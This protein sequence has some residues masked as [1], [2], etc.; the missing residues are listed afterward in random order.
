MQYT[1]IKDTFFASCPK[2]LEPEL[3][4]ELKAR[5]ISQYTE[6]TGGVEFQCSTLKAIEFLFWTRISSR[7]FKKFTSFEIKSE[8]DLY[9]EGKNIKWKSYLELDQTFSIKT[10]LGNSP[11]G[12]MWSQFKN[13]LF[14]SQR[15]K[16]SIVDQFQKKFNER[17]SVDTKAPDVPLL[18]RV[19]PN[20]NPHSRKEKVDLYL[21]LCGEPLSYRGYRLRNVD[22]P[23]R[24]NVA[25]GLLMRTNLLQTKK[26]LDPM[27]GS[28]TFLF[29]ALY[30]LADLPGSFLKVER[31]MDDGEDYFAFV[32]SQFY[33]KDPKLQDEVKALVKSIQ[34]EIAG[35]QVQALE[36]IACD[37]DSG[38]IKAVE[39]NKGVH[40]LFSIIQSRQKNFFEQYDLEGFTIVCNPPYGE[41]LDVE[42]N[43]S[44]L[45][46]EIA[47]HL[48]QKLKGNDFY[49]L[50]ASVS[51]VK[52][53]GLK[54]NKKLNIRNGNLDA[55]FLHYQ[56]Y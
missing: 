9:F 23:V 15:L 8:K 47:D 33:K 6:F 1:K 31:F 29:E 38:S 30:Q 26:V 7:V 25:A 20:D 46:K 28:G 24:E 18:M 44:G 27:A 35:K 40:P 37:E 53:F 13:T 12:K 17:P 45:Y 48:K 32:R 21:D 19:S 22:A 49:M 39:I 14:L 41:R 4:Q 34:N 10:L 3:I 52:G 11:N 51:G 43:M 42:E 36:L 55:K 54:P 2:G 56:I 5:K 50:S 16:D